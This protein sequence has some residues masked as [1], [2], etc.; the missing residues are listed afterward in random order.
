LS[1]TTYSELQTAVTDRIARADFTS[2]QTQECIALAESEIQGALRA[3]DMETKSV[4]FYIANEFEQVPANFLEVASFWVKSSTRYPLQFM[5]D[6]GQAFS[7]ST[8]TDAPKFYS[9]IGNQFHFAPIPD[10]SYTATLV[11]FTKVPAL[12]STNTTNW[13]LTANPDAYL[14]GACKHA[15]IRLQQAEAA[16]G[17]DTLYQAA[18]SRIQRASN[19]ARFGPGMRTVAA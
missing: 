15:A 2:A 4:A 19:R 12:S 5:S 10:S 1:I 7:Y 14:Y 18:I 8:G 3:Q 13:L 16:Q 11:Y 9:V 17:Y 6:D